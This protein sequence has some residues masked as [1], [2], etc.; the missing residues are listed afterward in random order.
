MRFLAISKFLLILILPFMLVLLVANLIGFDDLFYQE[1]FSEYKVQLEVPQAISLHEKVINFIKGENNEL[2]ADFNGREKQHLLDVRNLA[3][4]LTILLYIFIILFVL[5]LI[6]SALILK[7]NN[8]IINFVGKVLF[9]GGF[10]TITLAAALLFFINS[11]FPSAFDS[12][13]QLFFEKGTY[14]FDPAKDLIVK[15]YPEQLFMD[16]GLKISIRIFIISVIIIILGIFLMLK[17][18]NKKNK[19]K[20][21]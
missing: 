15:L 20:T 19:K 14:L 7:I 13:H 5:L 2:P 21:T 3:R 9:F 11:D 16:L 18:K 12:F 1:K 6:V 4:A 10:L 8:Y 17:S